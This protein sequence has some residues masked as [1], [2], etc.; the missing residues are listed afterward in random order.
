M[1]TLFLLLLL[2]L[3]LPRLHFAKLPPASQ[4]PNAT[5]K[6][7]GCSSKARASAVRR[8][9]AVFSIT[10]VTVL[11][12]LYS[13]E[14]PSLLTAVTFNPL[15]NRTFGENQNPGTGFGS[16]PFGSLRT[17]EEHVGYNEKYSGR[18]A[19]IVS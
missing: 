13:S 8:E 1:I 6:R 5:A 11:Y 12:L 2:L 9:L 18:S 16:L 19:G 15:T 7:N 4:L 10:T 14:E 3:F 17:S